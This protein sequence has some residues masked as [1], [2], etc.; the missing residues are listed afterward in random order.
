MPFTVLTDEQAR[1]LNKY[2][3]WA[4]KVNLASL[5][6]EV[7]AST[8]L[9]IF[10]SVTTTLDI[11]SGRDLFVTRDAWIGRNLN[12]GGSYGYGVNGWTCD[13]NGNTW[14]DGVC[15]ASDSGIRTYEHVPSAPGA[16]GV[17]GTISFGDIAGTKY[18]FVCVDTDTWESVALS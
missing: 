16:T 1:L 5:M 13:T 14:Q 3:P 2:T 10:D 9:G 4:D 6:D 12:V 17:K 8:R 15:D 7:L 18:L 11:I